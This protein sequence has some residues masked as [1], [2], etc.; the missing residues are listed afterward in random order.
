MISWFRYLDGELEQSILPEGEQPDGD[1]WVTDYG[2]LGIIVQ[3]D[4]IIKLT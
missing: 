3:E 1:G 4:K 2:D